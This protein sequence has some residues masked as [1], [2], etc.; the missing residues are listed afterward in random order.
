MLLPAG[1]AAAQCVDVAPG[2]CVSKKRYAAPV[3]EQPFFG[4]ADKTSAM[5]GADLK[6][7]AAALQF[8]SDKEEV[9]Q[10]IAHTAWDAF[11]A[12]DLATAG[13]RFNQV[14]L[15]DPQQSA[16]YHGFA[17]LAEKRFSDPVYAEELFLAAKKLRLPLPTLDADYARLLLVRN[18][19]KDALPLLEQAV[20]DLPA[21]AAAWSNLASARFHTG[22]RPGACEAAAEAL[23]RTTQPAVRA[24]VER[25]RRQASC[26]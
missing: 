7:V 3:N 6:F 26:G 11:D 21:F 22:D 5:V 12:N 15:I 9:A 19:P 16:A 4:F 14:F 17:A 2:I 10:R 8:N 24:D 1:L 13:R 18:R 20:K 23:R 25:L